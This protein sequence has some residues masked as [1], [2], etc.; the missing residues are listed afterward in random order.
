MFPLASA[1]PTGT[2][3]NA[4]F[5]DVLCHLSKV[6]GDRPPWRFYVATRELGAAQITM[7][8]PPDSNLDNALETLMAKAGASY[9]WSWHKFCG[10]A[11]SPDCASF[12]ISRNG[13]RERDRCDYEL[14]VSRGEVME[15]GPEVF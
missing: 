10:N 11:P 13:D 3:A 4:P 7:T 9:S 8:I 1:A 14:I 6:N 15:N 2:F 5:A 12:Y